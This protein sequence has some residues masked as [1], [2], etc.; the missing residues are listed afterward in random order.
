MLYGRDTELAHLLALL[1][2]ARHAAAGAVVVHGEPGVGKSA[3][4]AEVV[5]RAADLRVLRTQ[6]LESES[7]L[8]FA[9]LHRLLRPALGLLERLSPPQ[10]NALRVAFGEDVGT[11]EPFL[12]GIGTLSLLTEAAEERPVVCLVDDA[13]WL[14][15]ASAD[16]LLFATRRLDADRVA[17][18]FTA[19]D[20]DARTFQPEGVPRLQ[21]RG[22]DP[23]AVDALLA[24]RS[25]V[26]VDEGVAERLRVETGGN[27]LALVELPAG[28][29]D[30]Q[31]V[32]D[33]PLP[34]ELML[35]SGVERVF[36]ERCRRLS[37]PAQDVVLVAVVDDTGQLLTTQRAASELGA[38]AG[39]WSEA[40]RSGLLLVTGDTVSV[41]HPLVR[42]AVRQASDVQQRRAV[43]AALARALATAGDPDRATWHL[44]AAADGP[45]P[46]LAEA[47]DGVA[48]RARQ[49]GAHPIAADAYERAAD[50]SDD[51][52]ERVR[53]HSLAARDA[54]AAGQTSRASALVERAREQVQDPLLRADLDRLRGRI[55]M[56]V[57]AA[58]VGHRI[59]VE[60]A[61]RVAPVDPIRALEIATAAAVGRSHGADSGVRLPA[62]VIDVDAG[63]RDSPRT[64]CLKLLLRS[65]QHDLAGDRPSALAELSAAMDV[66]LHGAPGGGHL[67]DLDLLGNLGNAAL[68]V[69]DDDAQLR[70][71]GLMLSGARENGDG[72]SVL[73]ALQRLAFGQYVSGRWTALR[74]SSEEAVSLARSVGNRALAAA[75]LAWLALLAAVEGRSDADARADT[76]RDLVETH[77][78]AGILAQPVADL[79]RWATGARAALAGDAAGALHQLRQIE[80]PTIAL[81]AAPDRIEAAVRSEDLTRA[82][83]WVADLD[84]FVAR[85][86]LPWAQ[87]AAAYGRAMTAQ[88]NGSGPAAALELFERA[89]SH[90]ASAGRPYDRARVQLAY[91]EL[92]RRSQRRVDSRIPLRAA[93]DTL[94]DL[95][96][97]PLGE[98]A[99]QELRASGETARKRDP[100]TALD[101]TPMELKVAELVSHGLSNKDVASQCWVSPRTVAFHL[102]NVFTKTGV[103]SRGELAHLDL[104]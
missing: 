60:A 28:L 43:H 73:Y 41:R 55:E 53:R 26:A 16:A 79:G 97:A 71:Y 59:F 90:H 17:M 27:P 65:T 93:C 92:L 76:L 75:P 22:L 9:A 35:T 58:A 62:G 56:N 91:G 6:G 70:F 100:S 72:M 69:G 61:Q 50:L 98:R 34:A 25:P 11:V 39:A 101:L 40:E 80:L 74:S 18:L 8:A 46:D 19:R 48:E 24:E 63:T 31:L 52:Q 85:T 30:A 44:T 42:S 33:A 78:P 1:D 7:P 15:T 3:L 95:R 37:G 89:L 20:T 67:P 86:E 13:H 36:L 81:L 64:R 82:Q 38:D 99:A 87:A 96:A 12:V 10:A 14:D 54:W 51:P 103:T 21:L 102:R 5:A 88:A 68:H 104:T 23:A 84:A 83:A 29:S 2:G 66:A 47:L 94:G 32:G 77:P 57:G 49:R 4:L 45:D